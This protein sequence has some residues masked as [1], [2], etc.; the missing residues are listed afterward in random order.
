MNFYKKS[1]AYFMAAA[2]VFGAVSCEN[3]FE[4]LNVD[5]FNPTETSV[6]F[7]FNN[8]IAS[9]RYERN[10]KLYLNGQKVYQWS[11]LGVSTQ[12]EPNQVNDLGRDPVWTDLF[13]E[14]RNIREI[15]KR[16]DEYAGDQERM[17]NRRALINILYAYK[18]LRVTDVYG[19]LPYSEAGQ[20]ISETA[21][22]FR[23]KYDTQESIY[24]AALDDLKWAVDNIVV[25]PSATTPSGESY[26]TYGPTE[27]LFGNDMLRWKRLANALRLRYALRMS[28]VDQAGA[29]AIISDVLQGGLDGLPQGHEDMF[30]FGNDWTNVGP[31]IYWAF[32][33]FVGIRMGENAWA[34]MTENDNV[35]GSGI[36]D[37][38]VYVYF[39]PN[40]DNEWIPAPQNPAEQTQR[41]GE[42]YNSNRRDEPDGFDFRGTYSGFN[43]YLVQNNDKGHEF[44]LA[45]PEVCFLLAEIYQ[46]GL[47]SGDAQEWYEKGVR[48]SIEKWYTFGSTTHI[49]W[50]N[51]PAMPDDAA[52]DAF[53]QHPKIAYDAAN[54]LTLIHTQRWLD[55]MLQ[56]QEAWHLSRR[57]GLI[58]M[59]SVQ[60]AVSGVEEPAPRRL[61]YPEDER[62]N[63]LSNYEAQVSKMSGGDEL[64]TRV[65][66]DV[67]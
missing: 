28:N 57:S 34:H 55:L 53:L 30:A 65:W 47:A 9:L 24:Q 6:N 17:T 62:N 3:G 22:I 29:Q 46:R 5:P 67:N 63:N 32:E 12:E 11:Q 25:D 31:D 26:F 45:Y 58:P 61:R 48:A 41:G 8:V 19:D 36:I 51:P 42:P 23:P 13:N 52:I 37:P 18:T 38:R 16:L 20:G 7:L 14:T 43:F 50:A 54:G 66:W 4:D 49:N 2:F 59:L 64:S 40:I 1:L 35:D 60:N 33:F 44:H 56:P 39:E 21:Q 15:Y 10:E 27:T